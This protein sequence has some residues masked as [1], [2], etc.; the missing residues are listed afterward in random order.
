MGARNRGGS[1]C[2]SYFVFTW[3]ERNYGFQQGDELCVRLTGDGRGD[4]C[5]SVEIG[6]VWW[7]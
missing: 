1:S 4:L 7:V 3:G 2:R 5:Y 6:S